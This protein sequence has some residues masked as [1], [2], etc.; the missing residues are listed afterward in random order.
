MHILFV[1]ALASDGDVPRTSVLVSVGETA[2]CIM[3]ALTFFFFFIDVL[4]FL[5]CT[6]QVITVG[7]CRVCVVS[8]FQKVVCPK[9]SVSVSLSLVSPHFL[10]SLGLSV[11]YIFILFFRRDSSRSSSCGGTDARGSTF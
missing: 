6:R 11:F 8:S 9:F 10:F 1:F 7:K 5:T 3:A 2:S 4:L